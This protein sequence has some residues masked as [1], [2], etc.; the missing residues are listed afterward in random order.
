[1]STLLILLPPRERLQAGAP[2]AAAAR[3][4][5]EFD[6]A[7][8]QDDGSLSQE[9]RS[10][11]SALPAANQLCL[12]PS[13]GDYSFHRC[14]LPRTGA[15]RW[16]AALAGLLEERLLEDPEALHLALESGAS[17]GSEVWVC[18]LARAPLS[19]AIAQLEAAQR[20]VD[21]ISPALWP[22]A[23]VRGHFSLADQGQARLCWQH[24]EGAGSLPLRGAQSRVQLSAEQVQ[25]GDWSAESA[26]VEA[27]EAWLGHSVPVR[28]RAQ[29]AL[30]A[31]QSP[32]NLRQF[33]L[34][35]Q[36]QGLRWLRQ[37]GHRFMQR[38]WRPVRIGLVALLGLQLV[39][40]NALAWQQRQQVAERR[41]AIEASLRQAFP[42]VRAIV[43]APLQMQRELESLRAESGQTGPQDFEPLL[44]ALGA[45]WPE[46]RAPVEALNFEPGQ[47]S[48]PSAGWSEDQIERLRQRLASEQWSL[49]Q[50]QGRMIVRRSA[51]PKP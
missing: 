30:R 28:T 31:L 20:Y 45:A 33:D 3:A 16:R 18:A 50:E 6:W 38:S 13:D 25:G 35:E 10:A 11:P 27:A 29:Q 17:A 39:G 42:K 32:W 24:A 15:A 43:D 49:A 41:Q 40:L 46:D 37:L 14:S 19:E 5:S 12:V 51:P 4:R 48:L 21:R 36:V 44:A 8:V 26:A 7:L 1:M 23:A 9:G 34:A 47:I 2:V 22:D